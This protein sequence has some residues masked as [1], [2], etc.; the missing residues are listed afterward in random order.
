ML[1]IVMRAEQ[2]LP[3]P[4]EYDAH[5]CLRATPVTHIEG[6][7][8]LCWGHSSGHVASFA[9]TLRACR[10]AARPTLPTPTKTQH[11]THSETSIPADHTPRANRPS[12]PQA[13]P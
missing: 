11:F 2:Q 3:R 4:R 10:L 12:P 6:V 13:D 8:R 9:C 7:E 5:V 1:A